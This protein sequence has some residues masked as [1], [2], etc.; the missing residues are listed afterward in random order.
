MFLIS[1][2]RRSTTAWMLR[3]ALRRS[4]VQEV[5]QRM[6]QLPSRKLGLVAVVIRQRVTRAEEFTEHFGDLGV[7]DWIAG[8]VNQQ[9]L[10]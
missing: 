1:F 9:V 10:L 8:L 4:G 6:E 3:A 7:I 5:E 2:R